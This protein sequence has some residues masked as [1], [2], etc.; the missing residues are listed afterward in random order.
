MV[1]EIRDEET[2]HIACEAAMTGHLVL[3]TIHTNDATGVI[4]RLAE[5]GVAPY[6][7]GSTLECVLAQRLIRTLCKSCKE[8]D[9]NP[10]KELL[11]T[12]EE[13]KIDYKDATFMKTKGCAKCGNKGMKGR[14]AIHE[15][16]VTS[17]AVRSMCKPGVK[18]DEI[19]AVAIKAG[20][21]TLVEDGLVKITKGLT[22][23]EEIM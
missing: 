17:E 23:F 1:G 3:S 14:T 21:R 10:D 11:R 4:G 7:I 8:P 13:S 2:G 22:T 16:M 9:P 19:R 12:L 20:M 6:L 18:N 5:M 15:I